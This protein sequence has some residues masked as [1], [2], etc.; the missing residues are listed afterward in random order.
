M[1]WLEEDVPEWED[2]TEEE[3]E[4]LR[5]ALEDI[6]LVTDCEEREDDYYE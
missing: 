1:P 5:S 4:K 3:R 2:L 6:G